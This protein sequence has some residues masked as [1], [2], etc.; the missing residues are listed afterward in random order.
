MKIFVD[1]GTPLSIVS[2]IS[3]KNYKE[4]EEVREEELEKKSCNRRFRFGENVYLSDNEV[5]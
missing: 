3:L 4:Q 1:I 5:Y 2:E